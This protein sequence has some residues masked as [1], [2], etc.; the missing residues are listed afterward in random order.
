MKWNAVIENE[1]WLRGQTWDM[2]R[3]SQLIATVAD[4]LWALSVEHASLDNQVESLNHAVTLQSWKV[5]P[6]Q[7]KDET[8]EFIRQFETRETR[9]FKGSVALT[10]YDEI[11]L[12]V[13][14]RIRRQPP[15]DCSI[16]PGSTPVVAFGDVRRARFATLGLNP[17]RIEFEER[18]VELDGWQRRFE[19]TKSLRV[20]RLIDAPDGAVFQVWQ[21]CNN[22]FHGNPYRRWFDRLEDVL[23]S[24]GASYFDDSACHLDLSQWAT[25][26]TWGKL[27]SETK[28]RLVSEDAEFLHTQLRSEQIEVLLLNGKGVV[29]TFQTVLHTQLDQVGTIKDRTVTT[30]MYLGA[31][32]SV[33]VIGWSTNLQSSFGVTNSLRAKLARTRGRNEL[34]T[35]YAQR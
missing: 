1:D 8:K 4:L 28:K 18:G 2:Y 31:F 5:A 14:D 16:I 9:P 3:G 13:V 35:F 12:Y 29:D 11:P 26:P 22:Y 10:R 6:Q 32:G 20:A 23:I 17:S 30:K 19:T 15:A 24:L 34:L 21:R 33:R 25:D 7:L 27:P